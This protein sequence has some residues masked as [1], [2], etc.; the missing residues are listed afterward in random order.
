MNLSSRLSQLEALV[1]KQDEIIT[2]LKERVSLLEAKGVTPQ[3]FPERKSLT[4]QRQDD[5]KSHPAKT[6]AEK[7]AFIQQCVDAGV[8]ISY[9]CPEGRGSSLGRWLRGES[10]P[11][12]RNIEAWYSNAK[13]IWEE[14]E[15]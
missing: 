7:K 15:H 9:I 12:Q 11:M 5:K 13:S 14:R 6:N 8:F 4:L 3:N 2:H 1:K 10:H